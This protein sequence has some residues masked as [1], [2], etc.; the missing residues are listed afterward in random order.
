VL[1]LHYVNGT[2]YANA[3]KNL[4]VPSHS[5]YTT[6]RS[7]ATVKS[8]EVDYI[9]QNMEEDIEHKPIRGVATCIRIEQYCKEDADLTAKRILNMLITERKVRKTFDKNLIPSLQHVS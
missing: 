7:P 3:L 2:Q 1:G 6:A 4:I 8:S 5:K 9:S